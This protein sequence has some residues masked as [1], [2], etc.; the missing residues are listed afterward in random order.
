MQVRVF[1]RYNPFQIA[2]YVKILFSG[3][4]FISGVGLFE[5]EQGK[6]VLPKVKNLKKFSVM[7]EINR[8]IKHL[9]QETLAT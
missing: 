7:S 2:R 4:F 9:K 6:I 1:Q 3:S 8:H 5:F